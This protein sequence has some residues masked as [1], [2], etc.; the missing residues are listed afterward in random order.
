MQRLSTSLKKTDLFTENKKIEISS[1]LQPSADTIQKI[2]QF[3]SIY[4]AQK[5][6]ENQFVEWL[7][8]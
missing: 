5:T 6:D 7:L 3:A 2:L 4:R 1:P 8:N